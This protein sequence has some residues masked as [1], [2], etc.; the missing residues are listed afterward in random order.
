MD[1]PD[2]TW[3]EPPGT[4]SIPMITGSLSL[5]FTGAGQPLGQQ[6]RIKCLLSLVRF[7]SRALTE[8]LVELATA[9][10]TGELLSSGFLVCSS[11][12]VYI[13]HSQLAHLVPILF[14]PSLF[15]IISFCRLAFTPPNFTLHLGISP[16][17]RL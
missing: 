1:A 8:T 9:V 15:S 16:R 11:R 14:I 6:P 2:R 5:A 3:N 10:T 17:W 4:G 13:R 12:T 7:E